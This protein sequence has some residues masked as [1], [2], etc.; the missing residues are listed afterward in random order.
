MASISRP[1]PEILSANLKS[2]VI[3]VTGAAS[4]IGYATASLLAQHGAQ[5]IVVDIDASKSQAAAESIGYGAVSKACNVSSW[6]DQLELFSWTVSKF[7]SLDAVI[8]NAGIDPELTMS[9]EDGNP[10]KEKA[11]GKVFYDFSADEME[12]PGEG[13]EARL[14][15]PSDA[16]WEVNVKGPIYN[17]KL[18]LHYMKRLGKSGRVI[19]VGSANSY[20]PLATTPLYCASKHAVLGLVRAASRRED[21]KEAGITVSM[22]AP[23]TTVTPLTEGVLKNIPEGALDTSVPDDLAWAVGY[24][25]VAAP[26]LVNG[27]AIWVQGKK[28][29]EVEEKFHDFTT[30][31]SASS[32]GWTT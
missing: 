26:E 9:L 18:G 8:C 24:L 23:W 22:L 27:K 10:L 3:I 7:S 16:V 29:T 14:K 11:R 17:L 21:C 30:A 5:V 6:A 1:T 20:L 31:L 2:K 28:M 32:E 12:V 25:C 4:G 13:Q 19:L 15:A